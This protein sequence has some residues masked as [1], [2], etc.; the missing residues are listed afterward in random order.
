VLADGTEDVITLNIVSGELLFLI[1]N[2]EIVATENWRTAVERYL[3]FC[4]TQGVV[5][6]DITSFNDPV[7]SG[8]EQASPL[9]AR[10]S[11]A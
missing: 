3:A 7:L 2:D 5:P 4:R 8:P 1:A 6:R 11:V 10:R 9:L